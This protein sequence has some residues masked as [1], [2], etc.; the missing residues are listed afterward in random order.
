MGSISKEMSKTTR[1]NF[2]ILR[3]RTKAIQL[4]TL[5]WTIPNSTGQTD[6][7][8]KIPKQI[9]RSMASTKTSTSIKATSRPLRKHLPRRRKHWSRITLLWCPR[10]RWKKSTEMNNLS[11][12]S[13]ILYLSKDY[14]ALAVKR[15]MRI[16]E[17]R[18]RKLKR[19]KMVH[20]FSNC[21]RE[22]C[23]YANVPTTC[24]KAP[25]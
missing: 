7:K 19:W 12:D 6:K 25:S 16:S 3:L 20:M 21:H 4:R 22:W 1:S 5:C 14:Q 9:Q 11:P 24:R 8:A 17:M 13:N 2:K 23:Q 15:A 10:K 18:G